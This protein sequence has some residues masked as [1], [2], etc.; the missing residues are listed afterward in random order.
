MIAVGEKSGSLDDSLLY[1]ADFYE[2]EIDNFSKN[3][4][5]ILEPLM[6]IVIGLIVGF[7]A[8]AIVTPIYEKSKFDI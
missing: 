7:V 4:T 1:L 5:T 3:I 2:E 8:L 6:L